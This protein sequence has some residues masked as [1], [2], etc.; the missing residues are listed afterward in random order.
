MKNG[1]LSKLTFWRQTQASTELG[2]YISADSICVYQGEI[3]TEDEQDSDLETQN[4][5]K[6]DISGITKKIAFNG[7]NWTEAF[8]EIKDIFGHAK[9]KIVLGESF[10][11]LIV[12]D[13][14]N[15]EANEL[16]QALLW[17]VKDLATEPVTNI[18]L[19]YFESSLTTT[20]KIN[21]VVANKMQLSTLAQACEQHGFT[22]E[23]ISIEELAMPLLFDD[24]STHMVVSHVP[25][26][27]LLLTVVREGELFMQRRV[28]GFAQ[29]DK[30]TAA[31]L[32]YGLADNL[33]LEIQR[34]M[35]YFESQLRQAPVG[36][37]DLLIG[38]ESQALVPLV[39]QNFNQK[40]S[41]TDHESVTEHLAM[42]AFKALTR[43]AA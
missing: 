5:T 6:S 28:R 14:P 30:A 18:Q 2:L 40:V 8:A 29:I 4:Q 15:V 7:E 31:D 34:S 19:D 39:A 1:F 27:D 24:A 3:K 32:Q 36:S 25:E 35:D 33:S 20:G 21:V 13:K 26:H 23:G 17:S 43:G 16:S 42:M 12:A 11:Q 9:L 41:T 38:G 22:I 10:Y 37:I